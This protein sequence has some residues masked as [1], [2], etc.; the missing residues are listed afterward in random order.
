MS[1]HLFISFFLCRFSISEGKREFS[2][3]VSR[4]ISEYAVAIVRTWR[5]MDCEKK[6]GL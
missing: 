4:G 1:L 3:D 6:N 5:R 2:S